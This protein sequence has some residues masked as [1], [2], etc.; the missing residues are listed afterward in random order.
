MV[1]MVKNPSAMWVTWVQS[2]GWGDLLEEGMATY[3][4]ILACRIPMARG[5]WQA[6]MHG[7]TQLDMTLCGDYDYH[8]LFRFET[9]FQKNCMIFQGQVL[10]NK[11]S[12]N[13]NSMFYHYLQL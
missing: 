2:L 5:A 9:R 3:S 11:G 10:N 4:S 8:H 13:L 1:Q 12:L 6:T 7:I